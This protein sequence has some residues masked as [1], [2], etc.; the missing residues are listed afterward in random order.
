M[1]KQITLQQLLELVT[2]KQDS[3]GGWH[4]VDVKDNVQGDVSGYVKGD[5]GGDVCGDVLGSVYGT[6]N[7]RGWQY[8]ET[9]KER[10]GR[11]IKATGSKQLLEAFNQLEDN[12]D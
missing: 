5:V 1:T 2:V 6:I 9:P 4:I 7:G 8:I 3:N 12:N 11:L 10:L